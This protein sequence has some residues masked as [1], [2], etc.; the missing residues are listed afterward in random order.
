MRDYYLL[1]DDDRISRK[2]RPQGLPHDLAFDRLPPISLLDINEDNSGMGDYVD[3]L[4]KPRRMVSDRMKA[5][6]EQYNPAL[7]VKRTDLI[8]RKNNKHNVYWVLQVP[9]LECLSPESEFHRN[10]TV[11]R[12]VL[13]HKRV[14]EHHFFAIAGIMEPYI[15]VSLEAAESL[16]RR[17][18]TGFMLR[19]AEQWDGGRDDGTLG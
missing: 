2:I 17:G 14:K 11:K 4:D 18:L 15:V 19:K 13:D 6:L 9:E 16:L 5:I 3:W 12:L 10:G 1:I 8:D 7:S